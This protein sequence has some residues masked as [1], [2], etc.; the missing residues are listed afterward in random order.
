MF[1]EVYEV[2]TLIYEVKFNATLK[3]SLHP[4]HTHAQ[5]ERPPESTTPPSCVL[6]LDSNDMFKP[7]VFNYVNYV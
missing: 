5:I 1:E 2:R 4:A 3:S 7:I 6:M